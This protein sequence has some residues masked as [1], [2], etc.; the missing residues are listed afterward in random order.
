[1]LAPIYDNGGSFNGKTPDSRLEKML[2]NKDIILNSSISGIT[3][4]LDNQGK[5]ILSRDMLKLH[6]D[7]LYKSLIKNIPIIKASRNDIYKMIDGIPNEACSNVRKMFYKE[8]L[9]LRLIHLLEPA[10]EKALLSLDKTTEIKDIT[11]IP[12]DDRI[13]NAKERVAERRIQSG[14]IANRVADIDTR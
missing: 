2:M 8:T 6:N 5:N 7:N 11:D 14:V 10:Y 1:M 12:I 9:D 3:T 4:F 13:K